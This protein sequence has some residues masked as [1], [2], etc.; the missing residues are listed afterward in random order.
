MSSQKQKNLKKFFMG[1]VLRRWEL[2]DTVETQGNYWVAHKNE[3]SIMAVSGTKTKT[4]TPQEAMED[5]VQKVS[6]AFSSSNVTIAEL[7]VALA[8][9]QAHLY[10]GTQA[11]VTNL[12]AISQ[13]HMFSA[14]ERS[15]AAN[16]VRTL[17]GL[18]S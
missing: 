11:E 7:A 13:S 3:G 9:A 17:V 2:A 10:E 14:E 12:L 8:A 4:V 18:G 15:Q 1:F 5:A 6:N 16:K